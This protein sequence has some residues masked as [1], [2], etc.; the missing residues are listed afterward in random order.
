M[1][2][3][4]VLQ[5]VNKAADGEKFARITLEIL[6]H[7]GNHK[8]RITKEISVIPGKSTSGSGVSDEKN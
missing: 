8:Y 1:I 4:S 6:I 5:A 7:D 2:P 3:E